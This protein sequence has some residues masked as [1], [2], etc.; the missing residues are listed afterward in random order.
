M[1]EPSQDQITLMR[2]ADGELPEAE[3]RVIERRLQDEPLLRKEL[4][5]YQALEVL[6]R[7]AAPPEPA[8]LEWQ[9]LRAGIVHRS[10]GTLSW[11]CLGLSGLGYG[12]WVVGALVGWFHQPHP[13]VFL[14]GGLGIF[15]LTLLV[16]RERVAA[17]PLDPYRKVQR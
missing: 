5:A 15:L 11:L 17:L 9:A 14:L 7:N 12:L 8:E 1:N 16:L 2:Y 4:S 6:A 10:L 3:A 13:A